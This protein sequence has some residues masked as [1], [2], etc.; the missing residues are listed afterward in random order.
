MEENKV[1][2]DLTDDNEILNIIENY[3]EK[4]VPEEN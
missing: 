2:K 1:E 3:I 4:V